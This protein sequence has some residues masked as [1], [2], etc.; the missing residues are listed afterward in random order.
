MLPEADPGVGGIGSAPCKTCHEVLVPCECLSDTFQ[1]GKSFLR[2]RLWHENM[3]VE[4]SLG[5]FVSAGFL[6]R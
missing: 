2:G 1:E 5:G 6:R 4:A 3:G